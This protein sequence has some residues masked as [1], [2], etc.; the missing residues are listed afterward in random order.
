MPTPSAEERAGRWLA[1]GDLE[2]QH[3]YHWWAARSMAMLPAGRIWDAI[4]VDQ[5]R[6]EH[7]VS[8]LDGAPAFCDPDIR[9]IYVLVPAGT[10]DSWDVPGTVALGEDA[11][12]GVPAPSRQQRPGPY[13]LRL[14]D[15]ESLADPA[16]LSR[17]L[18]A[19]RES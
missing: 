2:P 16:Q 15:D 8:I 17:A 19:V 7:A 4:K 5:A 10:A 12:I 18:R 6:G 13:W 14:P 9:K 1:E 3:A 11:W